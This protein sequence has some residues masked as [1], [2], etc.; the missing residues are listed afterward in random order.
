M[1]ITCEN[2]K[3]HDGECI[4][5]LGNRTTCGQFAWKV[6]ESCK[7]CEWYL[8]MGQCR[9]NLDN[10]C[11][12]DHYSFYQLNENI[13]RDC[14]DC[15]NFR[16]GECQVSDRLPDKADTCQDYTWWPVVPNWGSKV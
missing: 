13:Q 8:G 12:E 1:S 3:W 9:L 5:G 2:C 14:R 4:L 10:E 6:Q 16:Y 11:A 7:G 15:D